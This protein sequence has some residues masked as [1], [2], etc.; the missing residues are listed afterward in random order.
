M[1]QVKLTRWYFLV[2]VGFIIAQAYLAQGFWANCV[3]DAAI[4]FQYAKNLALG[5][6]LCFHSSMAPVEG[7]SNPIWTMLL[8]AAYSFGWQDLVLVSKVLGL[9]FH[10]ATGL[11]FC[12]YGFRHYW[13]L[14]ILFVL[15]S[16]PYHL[17]WSVT[18]LESASYGFFLCLA[19]LCVKRKLSKSLWIVLGLI[20]FSR[21][22]GFIFAFIFAVS[23]QQEKR[24]SILMSA[25]FLMAMIFIRLLYFNDILPNTVWA[26][27]GLVHSS[28]PLMNV[29]LGFSYFWEY[30]SSFIK[31][32][33]LVLPVLLFL[34]LKRQWLLISLFIAHLIFLML[35]GGDWMRGWRFMSPLTPLFA[36]AIASLLW[37]LVMRFQE[38]LVV[39]MVILINLLILLCWTWQDDYKTLRQPYIDV[40]SRIQRAQNFEKIAL[41]L[42]INDPTLLDVDAGGT[43]YGSSLRVY[44]FAGLT[45]RELAHSEKTGQRVQE[46]VKTLRPSFIYSTGFWTRVFGLSRWT[47][48]KQ[49]YVPTN[50]G[51]QYFDDQLSCS[52]IRKDLVNKSN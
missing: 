27:W 5:H 3:D 23:D 4:S 29:K 10:I 49:H 48:L 42:N 30:F 36:Y 45:V 44:D 41:E 16:F 46:F 37:S 47:W 6:G 24:K 32:P 22:E 52:L 13:P 14:L 51:G 35:S 19:Y 2:C 9:V 40:S 50:T 34:I 11:L 15:F 21:P 31:F 25:I 43:A 33:F 8:A 17:Y 18:G 7:F 1:R 12:L 39:L 38:A 28:D 26:K 20:I